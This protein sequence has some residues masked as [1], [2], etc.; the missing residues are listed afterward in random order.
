MKA[1]AI[2]KL[3]LLSAVQ[4]IQMDIACLLDE[5]LQ[6]KITEGL[7]KVQRKSDILEDELK[8]K[9]EEQINIL[10]QLGAKRI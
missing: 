7:L 4:D 2:N 8:A 10:I 6:D 3:D 5:S 1:E 9:I